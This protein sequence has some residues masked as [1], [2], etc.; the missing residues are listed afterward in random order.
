MARYELLL[1]LDW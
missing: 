1:E